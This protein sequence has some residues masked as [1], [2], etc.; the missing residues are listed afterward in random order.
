MGVGCVLP[1]RR[2]D[3]QHDARVQYQV[4]QAVRVPFGSDR[5]SPSLRLLE[6]PAGHLHVLGCLDPAPSDV[7]RVGLLKPVV[8]DGG[9]QLSRRRQAAVNRELPVR[10][11]QRPGQAW[12]I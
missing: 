4:S 9:G 3:L 10:K 12:P 11:V 5:V 8:L 1:C 7:T 6:Q 2:G